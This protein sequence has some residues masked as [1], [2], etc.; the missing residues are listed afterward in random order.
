MENRN[1]LDILFAGPYSPNPAAL[2]EEELF[3][4]VFE[5]MSSRYDYIIVDTPPMA[6]LIDGAIVARYCDGAVLVIESGAVSF[7]LEQ[8]VKRQLE[9]PDAGFWERFSIRWI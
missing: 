5:E 3:G 9:R 2:L 6:D 8:K 1:G 4:K 7:R